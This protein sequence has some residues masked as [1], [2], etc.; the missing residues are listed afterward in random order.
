MPTCGAA[1]ESN[2]DGGV[3]VCQ[4]H[5]PDVLAVVCCSISHITRR[6]HLSTP[7]VPTIARRCLSDSGDMY[8]RSQQ[9][10]WFLFTPQVQLV[11]IA[12]LLLST[13]PEVN[14]CVSRPMR[15]THM[16]MYCNAQL[17]RC[18]LVGCHTC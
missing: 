12:H 14:K 3:D 17:N 4:W 15:S 5:G 8:N 9:H 11:A 1:V 13:T 6:H 16:M 7:R 2:G 10:L 18:F